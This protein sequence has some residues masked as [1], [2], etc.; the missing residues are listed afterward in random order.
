MW[1]RDNY[2]DT[3]IDWRIILKWILRD[4]MRAWDRIDLAQVRDK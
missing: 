3:G 4:R 1:E 2:Q